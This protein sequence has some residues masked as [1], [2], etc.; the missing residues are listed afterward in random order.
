MDENS[1]PPVPESSYQLQPKKRF[2]FVGIILVIFMVISGYLV[3]A[4]AQY[5]FDNESNPKISS[6][7]EPTKEIT[8]TEITPTITANP[9]PVEPDTY[10]PAQR[11][12]TLLFNN[13]PT[14]NAPYEIV[15]HPKCRIVKTDPV[16]NSRFDY[17]DR[18]LECDINN[19]TFTIYPQS[20]NHGVEQVLS[21]EQVTIN[22]IQWNRKKWK[23]GSIVGVTY[24]GSVNGNF[25]S[26]AAHFNS[27]SPEEIDLFDTIMKSF[28]AK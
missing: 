28:V 25:Y 12:S 5:N 23:D 22:N 13:D 24:N 8:H 16:T 3:Y 11:A 9:L 20:S 21:D 6:I 18:I 4:S 1:I 14:G 17:D 26:I 27:D 7:P 19:A 15:Y 10:P 2:L